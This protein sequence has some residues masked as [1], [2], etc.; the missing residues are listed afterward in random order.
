MFRAIVLCET[1]L[2]TDK[3]VLRSPVD[4][5]LRGGAGWVAGSFYVGRPTV[6]L[7]S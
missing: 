3:M 4:V 1:V 6:S 7:V 5:R 2:G